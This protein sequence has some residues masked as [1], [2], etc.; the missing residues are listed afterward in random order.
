MNTTKI[1]KANLDAD[2]FYT[3][4]SLDIEGNLEIDSALGWVKFKGFLKATGYIFA[5]AGS[6]IEA[7]KGIEAGFGIKAGYGIEAGY[8]IKA[9]KGIKALFVFSFSFE[10]KAKWVATSLLPFWRNFWAEM[11]PLKEFKTDILNEDN[12]WGNL[13]K[14]I[15]DKKAKEI[16]AWSGW[17]PIL[18]AH[19]EMFFKLKKRVEL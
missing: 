8:G 12:C 9:G 19:L 17:H 15:D 14:L 16:C 4:T 7:G 13:R 11:E 3:A 5:K 6:G 1:T 18:R 2:N 10:I